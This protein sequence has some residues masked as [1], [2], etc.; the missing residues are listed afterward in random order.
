MLGTGMRT[1]ELLGLEPRHIAEDGST[2]TIEQ[3]VCMDKGTA[4][5]GTPKSF[6]S[7]RCIPVPENLR[8][9]AVLLRDTP[10]WT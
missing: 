8:C 10:M 3:A 2:I 5:L 7:Y 4:T 9:Y 6:D 1:Q